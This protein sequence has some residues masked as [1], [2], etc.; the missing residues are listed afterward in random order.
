MLEVM[1]SPARQSFANFVVVVVVV[2]VLCLFFVLYKP[3]FSLNK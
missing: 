1:T 3:L 2:A